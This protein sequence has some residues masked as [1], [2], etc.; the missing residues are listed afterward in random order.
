MKKI[1]PVLISF[2]LLCMISFAQVGFNPD[3]SAPHPSAILAVKSAEKGF[4][5]PSMTAEQ[6]SGIYNPA[7]GLEVFLSNYYM[8]LLYIYDSTLQQWRSLDF[9]PGRITPQ[10]DGK[11]FTVLH[12][13]GDVAPATKEV[14]YSTICIPATGNKCWILQNLGASQQA[15]TVSDV[16]EAAAGWY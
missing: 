3:N 15:T 11:T 14:T 1:F 7:N 9:G 12:I 16:V 2:V 5:P 8:E 4:L 10:C 6:I 13:A